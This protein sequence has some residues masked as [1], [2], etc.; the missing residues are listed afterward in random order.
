MTYG[1]VG[2]DSQNGEKVL[3]SRL[4]GPG[5]GVGFKEINNVG[6][7]KSMKSLEGDD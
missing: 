2:A 1:F 5:R 7:G 3:V 4:E 6:R